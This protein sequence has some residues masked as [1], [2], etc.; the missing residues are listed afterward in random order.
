MNP[1]ADGILRALDDM[2]GTEGA[3]MSMT[4]WDASW[5][6]P[7]PP[8]AITSGGWRMRRSPLVEYGDFECPFCGAAHPVVEAVQASWATSCGS[9]TGTSPSPRSTRTPSPQPR[10]RRPPGARDGSGRCTICCS[11]HQDRSTPPASWPGDAAP[12]LDLDMVRFADDERARARAA[13]RED[14]LSGVRSGVNG[15]PTFFVNGV[16]HDGPI[17]AVGLLEAVERA[18]AAT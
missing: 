1:G 4:S 7:S 11:Q 9:S 14:F 16:R 2:A 3:V 10:P 17:D 8:G 13:V 12:E 5:S 18:A 6:C 15:T